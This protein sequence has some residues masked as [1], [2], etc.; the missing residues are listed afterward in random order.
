MS[1]S[2]SG[3]VTYTGPGFSVEEPAVEGALQA[4]VFDDGSA[5][6]EVCAHMWAVGMESV[7][8]SV[9]SS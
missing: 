9:R 5:H 7:D 3:E 8:L 2:G 1:W 4:G 6:T